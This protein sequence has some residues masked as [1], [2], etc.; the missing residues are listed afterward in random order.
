M[1]FLSNYLNFSLLYLYI[2][3]SFYILFTIF[4]SIIIIQH[5]RKNLIFTVI[6][7]I[8]LISRFLFGWIMFY[9]YKNDNSKVDLIAPDC[10]FEKNFSD[11][12]TYLTKGC[13]ISIY[14]VAFGLFILAISFISTYMLT[15]LIYRKRKKKIKTDQ[16]LIDN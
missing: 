13:H 5:K 10:V 14:D 11:Y 9:R 16:F 3:I 12:Y 7:F 4:F 2:S 15:N 6:L 8:A 1:S